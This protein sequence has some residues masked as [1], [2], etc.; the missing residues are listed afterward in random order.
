MEDK[1]QAMISAD[2]QRG[3]LLG[4]AVGDALGAAVEF[5]MPCAFA[6]VTDICRGERGLGDATQIAPRSVGIHR[7]E[8]WN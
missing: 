1:G 7:R 8:S 3:T 4:L 5:E 6:D 2:R